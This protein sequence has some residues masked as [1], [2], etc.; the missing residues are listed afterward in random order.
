MA[1]AHIK[2]HQGNGNFLS[3]VAGDLTVQ[4][5]TSQVFA[6]VGCYDNHV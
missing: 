6:L 4:L 5:N 1:E 2:P 3:P